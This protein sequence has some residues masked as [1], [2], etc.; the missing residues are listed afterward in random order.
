MLFIMDACVN[1]LICMNSTVDR[2]CTLDLWGSRGVVNYPER[3]EQVPDLWA[4]S[5]WLGK[6]RRGGMAVS[7]L[8]GSGFAVDWCFPLEGGSET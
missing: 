7:A 2:N 6:S 5:S 3:K 8:D 4:V 1:R